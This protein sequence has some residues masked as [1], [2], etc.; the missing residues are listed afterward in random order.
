VAVAAA[1]Q[2]TGHGRLTLLLGPLVDIGAAATLV[3][4]RHT[5]D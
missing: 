1:F 3:L 5:M 2:P 4:S